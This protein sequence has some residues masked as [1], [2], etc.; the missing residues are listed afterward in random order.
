M[1]DSATA[2]AA[3][4]HLR[5]LEHAKRVRLARANLK[6]RVGAG[7]VAVSEVV[8]RP[9]AEVDG[10]SLSELLM[11]QPR[12]GHTRSKRLLTSL[13]VTENKRIG[14]LTE[15]QRAALVARLRAK[16]NGGAGEPPRPELVTAA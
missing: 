7:E 12:W 6:R 13:G 2:V 16:E 5:A 15:R 4:Q 8:S 14:T 1:G 10:M 11:S 3:P 9:P